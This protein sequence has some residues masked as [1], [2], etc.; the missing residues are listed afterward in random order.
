MAKKNYKSSKKT[1]ALIFVCF[2][3]S[4]IAALLY[5]AMIPKEVAIESV[6]NKLKDETITI[7]P[8]S[9]KEMTYNSLK[10]FVLFNIPTCAILSLKLRRK[11]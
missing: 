7:I 5:I 4:C 10:I 2:T 8:I 9:T 11:I 3:I 1:N 6:T